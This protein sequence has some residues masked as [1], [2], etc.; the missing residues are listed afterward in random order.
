[1][2][3][4]LQRICCVNS[5]SLNADRL[6]EMCASITQTTMTDATPLH[7]TSL[8]NLGVGQYIILFFTVSDARGRCSLKGHTLWIALIHTLLC[9]NSQVGLPPLLGPPPERFGH[10]L[11]SHGV[12]ESKPD[13]LT[14][15]QALCREHTSQPLIKPLI[16]D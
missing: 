5:T 2:Q 6:L 9:P 1:M 11:Q 15:D 16:F 8:V 7:C 3:V 13:P 14:L 4:V 10:S 12:N